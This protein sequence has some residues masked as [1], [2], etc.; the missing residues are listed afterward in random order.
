MVPSYILLTRYFHFMDNPIALILPGM[1]GVYN[2]FILRTYFKQT[3]ESII[4]AAKIDGSSEFGICFRIALPIC[5]TG[6]AT[7]LLMTVM[8]YW[9][10]WYECL[11]YINDDRYL[12]LQFY[13]T[14]TMSNIDQILKNQGTVS[15]PWPRIPTET[16]RMAMCAL[17]A[18]PMVIV[19]MFFQKY[20]IKGINVGSVKG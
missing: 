7:M 13:L 8:N 19:F 15:E 1:F 16:T 5:K 20:F 14:R 17:A 18:G 2:T 9:N 3:S 4:E 11:M 12:T 10:S 6:V